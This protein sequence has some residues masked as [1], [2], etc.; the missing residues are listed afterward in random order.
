MHDTKC[1]LTFVAFKQMGFLFMHSYVII[2]DPAEG[3]EDNNYCI[4]SSSSLSSFFLLLLQLKL[5]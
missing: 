4:Y 3:A 1:V 5:K 2:T